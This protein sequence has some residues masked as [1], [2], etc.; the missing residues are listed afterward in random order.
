M[1]TP[2]PLAD[3]IVAGSEAIVDLGLY[4]FLLA[5]AVIAIG[6]FLYRKFGGK[7]R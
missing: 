1:P 2:M 7:T 3:I 6:G 4:G 5:G